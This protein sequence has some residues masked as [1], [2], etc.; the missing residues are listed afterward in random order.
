M[1][2]RRKKRRDEH[3][4][5]PECSPVVS[6]QRDQEMSKLGN[7]VF[8]APS[9]TTNARTRYLCWWYL[10]ESPTGEKDHD[11]NVTFMILL[12]GSCSVWLKASARNFFFLKDSKCNGRKFCFSVSNILIGRLCN[13]EELLDLASADSQAPNWETEFLYYVV[14]AFPRRS[15]LTAPRKPIPP[16]HH[17]KPLQSASDTLLARDRDVVRF[18]V[19]RNDS[20]N[21]PSE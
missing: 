13:V 3:T 8:N 19:V 18:S 14:S 5:S 11:G 21:E 4:A 1:P 6:Y 16:F 12:H 15:P 10:L 9:S 2:I 17:V 7:E 20:T